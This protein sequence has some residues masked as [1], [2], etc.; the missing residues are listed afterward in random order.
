MGMHDSFVC[1]GHKLISLGLKTC[2]FHGFL[3]SN[4]IMILERETTIQKLDFQLDHF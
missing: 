2:M 4:G 1:E 3:G